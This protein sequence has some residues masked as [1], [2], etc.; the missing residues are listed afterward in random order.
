MEIENCPWC[1]AANPDVYEL[2]RDRAI[3][4]V[5]IECYNCAARSPRCFNKKDAVEEWNKLKR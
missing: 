5:W 2:T 3:V 4:G 1:D